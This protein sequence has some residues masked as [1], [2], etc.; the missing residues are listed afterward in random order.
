LH[1][2]YLSPDLAPVPGSLKFGVTVHL[3]P[4]AEP[5]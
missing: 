2:I 4:F 3:S 5:A 1:E